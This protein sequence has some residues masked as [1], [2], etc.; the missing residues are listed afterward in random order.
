[1]SGVFYVFRCKY[2][3]QWGVKEIR[4]NILKGIFKCV[5]CRKSVTIKSKITI[6]L[7]LDSKGP[8]DNPHDATKICQALNGLRN[9]EKNETLYPLK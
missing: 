5:Y 7:N 6:G 8:W 2:C 9:G 3:G 1:M 4:T